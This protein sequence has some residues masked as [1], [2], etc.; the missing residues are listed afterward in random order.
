MVRAARGRGVETG[1]GPPRIPILPRTLAR[2]ADGALALDRLTALYRSLP[3]AAEPLRFLDAALTALDVSAEFE[4]EGMESIPREGPAVVVA[5]HPFGGLDGLLLARLLLARRPD[6]R[7]LGNRLL[8]GIPE[9]ADLFI[10][11]EVLRG[12]AAIPGNVGGMRRALRW[13]ESGGMLAMFPAGE[14][15]H[16]RLSTG[17]VIDPAWSNAA[18]R[19]VRLSGAPVVPVHF[20]GGNSWTFQLAGLVHKRLRTA[21]LPREL[22]N[23]RRRQVSVHVGR[24]LASGHLARID[25][26]D[27]LAS[28]LRLQT[29]ALPIRTDAQRSSRTATRLAPLAPAVDPGLLAAQ[30]GSLPAA[31]RLLVSGELSVFVVRAGQASAVLAEI[32]RLREITFRA[33][34]E[35]TGRGTD[36]DAYDDYYEHL[37]I[38]NAASAEIVGAYRIGRSDEILAARG[39]PGLYTHSLFRFSRSFFTQ[40]RPALE[41]GRSFVR[42]EYQRSFAPLLLLWKG[43]AAYV[44]RHPRYSVLFGAVSISNDYHPLSREFLCEFLARDH[45]ASE[46]QRRVKPR[47]LVRRRLSLKPL[48]HPWRGPDGIDSLDQVV[49]RLEADGKGV[50]VLLRQYLKLGGR[51]AGFNLDPAFGDSID[52]LLVVDLCRTEPRVLEKYMG[53]AQA[54]AFAVHQT[55]QQALSA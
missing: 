15:S 14:V 55:L 41:L 40:L 44:A 28:H 31:N 22:L 4:G 37:F 42:Q 8:M 51:I 18:A 45:L 19:L 23:K 11:V 43:I 7:I 39:L 24:P 21:L 13:L 50:P 30:V 26:D 10:G 2:L 5:N 46:L 20:S 12:R 47:Q 48:I 49:S 54:Q 34:G 33:V 32:G 35:G 17:G 38:W 16:L 9:L 36:L 27:V 3:D 25:Q 6:V 1:A 29:Y 53:K 52:C